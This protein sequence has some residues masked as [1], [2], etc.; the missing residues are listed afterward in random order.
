MRYRYEKPEPLPPKTLEPEVAVSLE[1]RS[2]R[3]RLNVGGYT[4]LTLNERGYLERIGSIDPSVGFRLD[5]R[6][7]V[8]LNPCD[9]AAIALA[10]VER[11]RKSVKKLRDYVEQIA[12]GDPWSPGVAACV[13]A[14]V[15]KILEGGDKSPALTAAEVAAD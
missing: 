5:P 4:I 14:D 12:C 1:V 6:D 11:L 13:L 3:V 9:P 10:E 7:R 8:Q 15:D 2:D